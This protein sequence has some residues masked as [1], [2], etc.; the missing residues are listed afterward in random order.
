MSG[1]FDG[2]EDAPASRSGRRSA[3]D[4]GCAKATPPEGRV[5][6]AGRADR[7]TRAEHAGRATRVEEAQA[8]RWT[9][10]RSTFWGR[11]SQTGG[12]GH[13]PDGHSFR[14]DLAMA[15]VPEVRGCDLS[16]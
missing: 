11:R 5:Q 16:G 7:T 13:V 15:A 6:P 12:A 2:R 8:R 1:P 10:F 9:S 4:D 3:S 14:N